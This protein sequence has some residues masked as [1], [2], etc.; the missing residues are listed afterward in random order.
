MT[1]RTS[2]GSLQGLPF[3]PGPPAL[4]SPSGFHMAG[5][6]WLPQA[7][8]PWVCPRRPLVSFKSLRG[9]LFS[10]SLQLPSRKYYYKD[11]Y[12][13]NSCL[14]SPTSITVSISL[15][16]LILETISRKILL[17]CS[18]WNHNYVF[19]GPYHTKKSEMS[20]ATYVCGARMRKSTGRRGCQ[21]EGF[22]S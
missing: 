18:C 3:Q 11:I 9:T 12:H 17:R 10:I 4:T 22:S 1:H 14:V 15:L 7:W 6:S 19:Y 20:C 21:G 5:G 13:C 8:V 2:L 16:R